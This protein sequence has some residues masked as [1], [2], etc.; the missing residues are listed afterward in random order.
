MTWPP[1]CADRPT[2]RRRADRPRSALA[3]R[4]AR[5][6]RHDPADGGRVPVR[7]EVLTDDGWLEFQE[8]FVHRHQ[9][10]AVREVRFAGIEAAR[11]TP[12]VGAA[13]DG[14]RDRHRRAVE[15]DR[16]DRADPRA[17]RRADRHR[18]GSRAAASPSSRSAGSSAAR[19]SRVRP[20]GCSRRWARCRARSASPA[21]TRGLIDGFV[22]DDIDADLR[23]DVEGL[24]LRVVV[25]DTIMTDDAARSRLA[26]DVLRFATD[27]RPGP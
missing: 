11:P 21:A 24:G 27:L 4:S 20:T 13:I 14:R 23:A 3:L 12:E 19:R 8:Y 16:L 17:R 26:A 2:A 18:G 1:T 15:P 7:T 9:E 10:P 22:L 25:T 6:R 5:H